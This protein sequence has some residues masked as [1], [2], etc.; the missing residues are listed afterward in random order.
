VIAENAFSQETINEQ[1]LEELSEAEETEAEDEY[2]MQQL[3]AL[4]H[5]PLNI[6]DPSVSLTEL[7][8]LN[9][10]LI[11]NLISYRRLLGNLVSVYE[12]Q[13]VPG[14]TVDIIRAILPYITVEWNELTAKSMKHRFTDG[15]H[16]IVTRPSFPSKLYFRYKYQYRNSLQYGAIGERDAG[17]KALI[18]FYSVHLFIRNA[19]IIKSLALGDYVLNVGQGLIHWQSQA[20]KKTSSVINVKRQGDIIRPY[21]SAGEYNFQRGAAV[22]FKKDSWEATLFGSFR[23]ITTNISQDDE[24][25]E[26]IT[27]VNTSGLH[28]TAS[29]LANKNNASVISYGASIKYLAEGGHLAVNGIRYLYSTPL[30]KRDEPYNFFMIKGRQWSNYSADYSYTYRN[31]HF[32]GEVAVA[33][34]QSL[35]VI[36][37]MM[38]TLHSSFDIA[39]VHR[40]ISEKYQSLYGNAFTEN[41]APANEKG[42]YMG[43]SIK[44]HVNW[45]IDGYCDVFRFPWLKYRVDAPAGGRQQFVQVTW[46]PNRLVEVYSR[47]RLKIKPLNTDTEHGNFP[48]HRVLKNWRT[49]VSFQVSRTILLRSRLEV[50]WFRQPEVVEPETGYLIYGDVVYKP[51]GRWYS[52]SFRLQFFETDSY[53]TRLYAY[54]N[55]VLFASSTPA[56]SGTGMRSYINLRGKLR[57]R[58]FKHVAVD[59]GMKTGILYYPIESQ[60]NA[61]T[62]RLT[63]SVRLQ[64]FLSPSP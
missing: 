23:S 54:E 46:K 6:N 20:F 50:C 56:F 25:G 37:G 33:Q 60:L 34:N 51:T 63:E 29:E 44:P 36:N 16:S 3:Q 13:V 14:F 45:R 35:G 55:D 12:L 61:T 9:A 57:S 4:R 11:N 59:F 49:H 2:D 10:L 40:N 30:L 39:I 62:K 26:V 53:D 58:V 8:L 19:G 24:Y 5:H 15:A 64:L 38:A 48:E 31:I 27:S 28:R 42:I 43:V 47:F 21:H 18:D 52:A 7:P 1:Q 22:T 32:F 41:T 17:E